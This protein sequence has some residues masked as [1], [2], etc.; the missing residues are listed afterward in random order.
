MLKMDPFQGMAGAAG[1]LVV[2]TGPV[3]GVQINYLQ[4]A[5][6]STATRG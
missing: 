6:S 4:A 2:G 1:D 5:M 3:G